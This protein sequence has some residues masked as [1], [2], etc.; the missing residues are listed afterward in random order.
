MLPTYRE[1]L[2]RTDAPAGSSWGLFGS[3]DQ[4]GTLNF[5]DEARVRAGAACV[6][7]GARF[8]LNLRVDMF[9]PCLAPARKNP[10]HHIFSRH[11]YHR[12][13]FLDGFY[14]QGSSQIDSLRHFGHPDHGFYN[15]ADAERLGVA[16][17]LLGI[18]QVVEHGV[19]GRAVLVDLARSRERNGGK[20]DHRAGEAIPI[21]AVENALREQGT[22]VEPGDILLLRFGWIDHYTHHITPEERQRMPHDLRHPGLLQAHETVE[23]LWDNRISLIATDT[24]SVECWP[25]D[26]STPFLTETERRT[27]ERDIYSGLLHRVLIPLLGMPLGELWALDELALDCADD[28]TY[29][30]MVVANPLNIVGGV[31]SPANAVALK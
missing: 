22:R 7:R 10:E 14:P 5:L 13:D 4:L 6:R 8:N 11:P 12:D 29:E 1:L 21:S 16:D 15:G 30:C 24:F 27:G 26:P 19:A 3:D 31:G 18:N 23:W 9:Q 17:P 25:A 2:E 28:G 20:I